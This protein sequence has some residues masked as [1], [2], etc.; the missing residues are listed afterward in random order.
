[1][2]QSRYFLIILM[3]VLTFNEGVS[4]TYHSD[5]IPTNDC[6]QLAEVF[7]YKDFVF[8]KTWKVD[9]LGCGGQRSELFRTARLD[10]LIGLD[11]NCIIDNLGKPNTIRLIE[12]IKKRKK[13]QETNVLIV[14]YVIHQSCKLKLPYLKLSLLIENNKVSEFSTLIH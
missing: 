7:G 8:A 10:L 6:S 9:S 5:R 13:R 1:M 11:Y 2:I 3:M 4:Q 12:E 14:E